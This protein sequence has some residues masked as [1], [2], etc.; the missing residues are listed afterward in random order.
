MTHTSLSERVRTRNRYSTADVCE[1]AARNGPSLLMWRE[2]AYHG[3]SLLMWRVREPIMDPVF[4]VCVR[5]PIMLGVCVREPIMDP[6]LDV[7]ARAVSWTQSLMF[8]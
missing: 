6:V 7:C 2:R 1:R 4:D 5:E 3:P 8:V